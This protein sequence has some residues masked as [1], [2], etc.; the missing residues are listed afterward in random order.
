MAILNHLRFA[1][2]ICGLSAAALAQY[3]QAAI[4]GTI[5]DPEGHAI[6]DAQI[7]IQH[8]GTGLIRTTVTTNAGVFFLNGFPLGDYTFVVSHAG[9]R[10]VRFTS[11]RLAVGQTRTIDVTLNLAERSENVFVT[12]QLR[13][14]DQASA[15]VGTRMEHEQVSELPLNGRNWASMLPLIAGAVDPGTSD[16]RS[17]RF[18]G[19]GR[20]DNNFTLDGV[21][22]RNPFALQKPQFRLNQ[23]GGSLGGPV[24]KNKTFVFVAFEAFRRWPQRKHHETG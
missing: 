16:Q 15:V 4:T 20:D 23:F 24:T 13:E 5:R 1:L 10:E 9:F 14:V 6:P 17:V 3:E 12:A 19:H 22:A 7:Q 11:I 21:D 8:A 2:L 18:A